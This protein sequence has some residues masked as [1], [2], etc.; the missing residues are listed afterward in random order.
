MNRDNDCLWILGIFR[1]PTRI[2]C[3]RH[4][5]REIHSLRHRWHPN[6][7]FLWSSFFSTQPTD[8]APNWVGVLFTV[9]F[10][11]KHKLR[12]TPIRLHFMFCNKIQRL[13]LQIAPHIY[14]TSSSGFHQYPQIAWPTHVNFA[15]R[16]LGCVPRCLTV[17]QGHGFIVPHL[18]LCHSRLRAQS[19]DRPGN[20]ESSHSNFQD[21]RL[22]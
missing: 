21:A 22:P 7:D 17:A 4:V 11:E 20:S 8:C 10:N 18:L 19:A 15:P 1:L 16:A 13:R 9:V 14:S 5:L 2:H 3:T 12:P 6:T